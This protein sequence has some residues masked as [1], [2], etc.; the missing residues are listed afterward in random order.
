MTIIKKVIN[1]DSKQNHLYLR[2]YWTFLLRKKI[3]RNDQKHRYGK[4]GKSYMYIIQSQNITTIWARAI[5]SRSSL[6]TIN[7]SCFIGY[8]FSL[9]VVISTLICTYVHLTWVPLCSKISDPLS[10][11][12]L[13]AFKLNSVVARGQL[14]GLT[15]PV[16]YPPLTL[17]HT[18]RQSGH[19]HTGSLQYCF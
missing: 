8:L 12:S 4:K 19:M 3:L 5:A 10:S 7:S 13:L 6:T 2:P 14:S 15:I 16:T 17:V 9:P 11:T 1:S 18:D